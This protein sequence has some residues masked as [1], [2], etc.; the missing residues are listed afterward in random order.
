VTVGGYGG[1]TTL[2]IFQQLYDRFVRG[3]TTDPRMGDRGKLV[4]PLAR[5]A[6][7]VLGE[8]VSD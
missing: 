8:P 7:A 2:V 1:R 6:L 5:Q 3:E 4:A